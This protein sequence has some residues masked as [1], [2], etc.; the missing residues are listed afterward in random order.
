V[1]PR[2]S[3]LEKQLGTVARV[4]LVVGATGML[5]GEI[6]RRLKKGGAEVRALVRP[7]SPKEAALASAGV[8]I[9]QGDLKDAP[10][11]ASACR[12]VEGVI[13][14][15]TAVVSRREGDSLETVDLK[16]QLALVAAARAAGVGRFV[17]VSVSPNLSPAAPLMRAKR[18]VERAVRESGMKWTILQPSDFMEVWL[19]K[20]RGWDLQAGTAAIIGNGSAPVSWI[21]LQDVAQYACATYGDPKAHDR[22]VPLGGPEAL[23]PLEVVKA[24]EEVCGRRFQV[25]HSSGLKPWLMSLLLRRKDPLKASMMAL[26][27]HTAR[28]DVIDRSTQSAFPVQQVSVRDYARRILAS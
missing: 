18:T 7:G 15:A 26:A 8:A 21:S 6:C 28:G 13:S 27:A 5:G 19:G 17:F 4:I 25:Q 2:A 11:L 20:R 22:D 16:G 12:G 24:F 9:A 3:T 1:Y 23:S 10:S 14:T